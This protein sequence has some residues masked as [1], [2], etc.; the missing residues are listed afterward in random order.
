M[1]AALETKRNHGQVAATS[2]LDLADALHR[3]HLKPTSDAYVTALKRLRA[4]DYDDREPLDP[5]LRYAAELFLALEA[6]ADAADHATKALRAKL[7]ATMA[8]SGAPGIYTAGHHVTPTTPERTVVITDEKAL[9][10][11]HPD[12]FTTPQPKPDKKAI[13]FW[14]KGGRALKGAELSN[15]S[16]PG[17]RFSPTKA[18]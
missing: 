12:L 13:A 14:L 6:M 2:L 5:A 9:A 4:V 16:E 1:S 18:K 15:G 3:Q 17:V 10:A 7:A 11:E 8:D